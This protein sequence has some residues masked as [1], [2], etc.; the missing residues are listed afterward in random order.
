MITQ[1]QR[2]VVEIGLPVLTF[3]L[4]PHARQTDALGRRYGP[5]CRKR[6]GEYDLRTKGE[7]QFAQMLPPLDELFLGDRMRHVGNKSYRNSRSLISRPQ[8]PVGRRQHRSGHYASFHEPNGKVQQHRWG[9]F[10]IEVVRN[11]HNGYWT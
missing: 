9:T 2:Q 11:E 6:V 4:T 7:H 5:E 3:V 1:S 8:R 10:L